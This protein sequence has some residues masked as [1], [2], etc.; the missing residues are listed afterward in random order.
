MSQASRTRKTKTPDSTRSAPSSFG[1]ICTVRIELRDSNPLI[2][3][4]IEVPTSI[5]LD[6]LHDVIQ[7]AVGW[8]DCHPW[9]FKIDKQR[10]GLP[11]DDDWGAAPRAEADGVYLCDVLKPRKT[12]VDYLYDF[13]DAWAHRLTVTDIRQ[14]EPGASYPRYVGGEWAGPPEDCGGIPGFYSMLDAKTDPEHPSHAEIT[15]WFNDYDPKV[16]NKALLKIGLA[17]MANQYDATNSQNAKK[18][19][20]QPLDEPH[21][22]PRPS[23]EGYDASRCRLSARGRYPAVRQESPGRLPAPGAA[24]DRPWIRAAGPAHRHTAPPGRASAAWTA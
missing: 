3:R 9:E 12:V 14:G 19:P 16:I 20:D 15:Q 18:D 22:D 17:R 23:P 10:Y 21:Q 7:I 8:R 4:Q 2:W 6:V 11:M 13:G 24:A 1:R 5:T